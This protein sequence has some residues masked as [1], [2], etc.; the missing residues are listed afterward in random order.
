MSWLRGL[1]RKR[2]PD[3]VKLEADERERILIERVARTS[4]LP[5]QELE[6]RIRQRRLQ[7]EADSYRRQR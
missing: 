6:Q 7:L 4:E 5:A 2:E 3:P 1:F